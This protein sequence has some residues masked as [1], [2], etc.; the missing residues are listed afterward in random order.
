MC[1]PGRV[2]LARLR[3]APVLALMAAAASPAGAPCGFWAVSQ[4]MG[5]DFAMVLD[6]CAVFGGVVLYRLR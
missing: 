1:S 6:F 3:V 2:H 4:E 5:A